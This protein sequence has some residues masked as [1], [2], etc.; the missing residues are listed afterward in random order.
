MEDIYTITAAD[1]RDAQHRANTTRVNGKLL[2]TEA[3]KSFV[4][5]WLAQ[6]PDLRRRLQAIRQAQVIATD[7]ILAKRA[8]ITE[9][10][11]ACEMYKRDKG[12]K[13]TAHEMR[14]LAERYSPD[15]QS[16]ARRTLAEKRGA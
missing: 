7:A 11:N 4:T 2:S 9:F 3:R 10:V 15:V 16:W 13:L 14:T 5:R 8:E 1:R 6:L 12:A